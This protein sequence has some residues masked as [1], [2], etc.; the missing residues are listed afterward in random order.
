MRLHLPTNI[1]GKN[2]GIQHF[3]ANLLK[4]IIAQLEIKLTRHDFIIPGVCYQFQ[5]CNSVWKLCGDNAKCVTIMSIKPHLKQTKDLCIVSS[6][7][8]IRKKVH[9]LCTEQ[10]FIN[11]VQNYCSFMLKR[12]FVW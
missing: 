1:Y 4:L 6:R 7:P 12:L 3:S 8:Q 2:T 10:Q 9:L 11:S 5:S